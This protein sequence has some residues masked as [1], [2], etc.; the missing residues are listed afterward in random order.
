MAVRLD[1]AILG[2]FAVLLIPMASLAQHGTPRELR[3]MTPTI[4]DAAPGTLPRHYSPRAEL[5]LFSGAQERVHTQMRAVALAAIERGGK[6]GIMA[7]D[8]EIGAFE[9][10]GAQV[11]AIGPHADLA[12]VGQRIFASMRQLDQRGVDLI[13]VRGVER[14]GI[15]LAIW[16]RLV[17]AAEGQ[18]VEVD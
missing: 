5:R 11:V 17:R 9:G 3:M 15:G 18:V 8:E 14:A 2:S 13:L 6:V 1:Y 12:L 16:D 7:L 4:E 10:L